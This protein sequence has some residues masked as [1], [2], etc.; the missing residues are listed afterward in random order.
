[1]STK[2][3]ATWQTV[4]LQQFT[5]K[6]KHRQMI[7]AV[8]PDNLMQ[9]DSLLAL[10]LAQ[11]YDILPLGDEVEF[12]HTF[13]R[14]Y[15]QHWDSGSRKHLIVIVHALDGANHI[16]YDVY[17]KSERINLTVSELFPRLNA[18]V[19][20]ELDNSYYVDLYPAHQTN[21]MKHGGQSQKRL[22]EQ[23][24]IEFILRSVFGL[25]P[26][27]V[28][29]VQLTGLLIKKH[30]SRRTLPRALETYLI[31]QVL[32]RGKS[33]GLTSAHVQDAAAF[34]AWLAGQWQAYVNAIFAGL[35]PQLDFDQPELRLPIDNL[36]T[37]GHL[38]RIDP[39]AAQSVAD[40]PAAQ[41][42][43][44]IGLNRLPY[45]VSSG[46]NAIKETGQT[47]LYSL[48]ARLDA[49]AELNSASFTLR[50]WLDTGGQW[51]EIIYAAN[52]MSQPDYAA[53][54]DR[55]FAA[56]RQLD[57]SF[58]HFIE[59]KYSSISFYD[60]NQ[61]P[62]SLAK[63]NHWLRQ[64]HKSAQERV[65]LICFDGLAL[66]QWLLL[67]NY[68]QAQ[69]PRLNFEENRIFAIAP[70]I[71][72]ISRQ[73][74][75]AGELPHAFAN[76]V[77]QTNKDGE[78]WQRFWVNYE[79]PARRVAYLHVQANGQGLSELKAI[80]DGHNRRLGIV[81]NLFDD[82]MH[83]TKG[84]TAG[85]DKRVYYQTL[86][87]QLENGRVPDL[88]R[89]LFHHGYHVYLTSDHGNFSGVGAGMQAPKALV[90][91]YAKR[92]ALFDSETLAAD[93]AA[94][95]DLFTFHTKF[96]PDQLHAVYLPERGLLGA[97]GNVEISHGGLSIEE[98]IVPLVQL[99]VR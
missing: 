52:T 11:N 78:R 77:Y 26:V 2:P 40:L 83:G 61:G 79:V 53:I 50:D 5:P 30:Y 74:L 12:R 45:A 41:Q 59:A 32:P 35:K 65:A 84:M 33:L 49:L 23:A 82:V 98:M 25:D 76:T 37:D 70:T 17:E 9:D 18:I 44:A 96:L 19:T 47:A 7:L 34:Y 31:E 80:T 60:D 66:D 24:T 22:N 10:L 73:A 92:V 75:F 6:T 94:A 4:I 97:K 20:R 21:L 85:A 27:A 39:P 87:G 1:M 63:I 15:R 99:E 69:F 81:V 42:W 14:D 13:E 58:R 88:F 89:N 93:F 57:S 16:P 67:R 54:R 38:Q 36:F 43:L 68:L 51:A 91:K 62:I 56:R 86:Q 3:F 90:E 28:N 55:F 29:D 64:R 95:H 48:N 8:D 71:T 72:P 46:A